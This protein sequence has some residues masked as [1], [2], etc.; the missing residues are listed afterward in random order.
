MSAFRA[1]CRMSISNQGGADGVR[2]GRGGAGDE[3]SEVI[4]RALSGEFTWLQA[5]D[6][7]GIDPRSLRRWRARY[8]TGER[9]ALYDRRQRPSP[10]KAPIEEVQRILRLYRDTY[11]GFN[12]R[13]FHQIA[14][15][16]Y[17]V[18]LSYSFVKLAL[19]E[20]GLVPTRH[21]RGR[22]RRRREP[23]ACFGELLAIDGSPHP[24]LARCPDQQPTMI[25]VID[26]AT[27]GLLYAQLWPAETTVA[28]MTAPATVIR[29]CGLPIALDTDRAGWAFHTPKAGGKVDRKRLTRVGRAWPSWASSTSPPT[30]RRRAAV[31]SASTARCK[32]ASSTN[33]AWRA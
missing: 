14:R 27:K 22:H 5:A 6:I 3:A 24:W 17:A 26:D 23:R 32:I 18:T 25:T 20:A 11:R 19:Q 15:R 16:E 10:R 2:R 12:V 29:T 9:L 1:A 7:I 4:L 33:C 31:S 30:R 21:A 8:A 13:H 28:I